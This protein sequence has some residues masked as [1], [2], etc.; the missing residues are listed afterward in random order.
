MRKDKNK[1]QGIDQYLLGEEIESVF[2]NLFINREY[3]Y[4]IIKDSYTHKLI[5]CGTDY[6]AIR[7]VEILRALDVKIEYVIDEIDEGYK[8]ERF[9]IVVKLLYSFLDWDIIFAA[10]IT[11]LQDL[12]NLERKITIEL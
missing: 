9:H 11:K 6:E 5:I 3:L 7:I 10:L 8:L 2:S 4:N 1:S 12:C